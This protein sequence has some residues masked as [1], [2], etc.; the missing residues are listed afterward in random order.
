MAAANNAPSA[1]VDLFPSNASVYHQRRLAQTASLQ[2]KYP[3]LHIAELTSRA[4]SLHTILRDSRTS[5]VDFV[6]TADQLLRQLIE[7][8]L[9]FQPT[10]CMEILT[11][12]QTT[13]MGCELTRQVCGVSIVRAGEAMEAALRS[14]LLGVR[15]G[16]ILIQRDESIAEKPAVFFYSKLPPKIEDCNVLLLDPMLASGGS[17]ICA[18]RHLLARGVPLS[19]L[20]FVCLI[21][22]PEGIEALLTEFPTLTIATGILDTQLDE[23][24]YILPGVGDFG[25][26]Y[27]G[28][29]EPTHVDETTGTTKPFTTTNATL[30]N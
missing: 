4:L 23:R 7:F 24:K 30:N 10:R 3:T 25:D 28:T 26:R 5:T 29:V 15:I 16:K 19:Q 9:I 18:I 11:P 14:I 17:A 12:T 13:F 21:S 8:A 20:T 22:S 6:H 1:P 2:S 27:Y